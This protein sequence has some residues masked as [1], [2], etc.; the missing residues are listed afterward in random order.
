MQCIEE[1]GRKVKEL[2]CIYRGSEH[3][4]KANDFHRRCDNIA[5]TLTIIRTEFNKTIAAFTSLPWKSDSHMS[6]S[7]D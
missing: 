6:Y 4:F 7:V 3:G 5:S 2:A 1:Q